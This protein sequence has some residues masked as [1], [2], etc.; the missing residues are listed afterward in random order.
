MF[1]PLKR[2][3]KAN[4]GGTRHPTLMQTDIAHRSAKTPNRNMINGYISH[5]R[6]DMIVK[7]CI[8]AFFP[9]RCPQLKAWIIVIY[10]RNQIS[11]KQENCNKNSETKKKTKFKTT[12]TTTT[13]TKRYAEK[14]HG[15]GRLGTTKKVKSSPGRCESDHPPILL[16]GRLGPVA[17]N[18]KKPTATR[19][20]IDV[21]NIIFFEKKN[22]VFTNMQQLFFRHIQ[23]RSSRTDLRYKTWRNTPSPLSLPTARCCRA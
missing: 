20:H 6:N 4:S 10:S 8:S 3:Q 2:A 22:N 17:A 18:K 7:W 12:T 16:V 14:R 11:D 19:K 15:F 13:T 5:S 21:K 23:T 9:K 1:S